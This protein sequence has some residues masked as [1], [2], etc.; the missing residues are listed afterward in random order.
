MIISDEVKIKIGSKSSK[1]YR[2]KKYVFNRSGDEIT[3]KIE[4]LLPNTNVNVVVKCDFCNNVIETN[5]KKYYRNFNSNNLSLFSCCAKCTGRKIRMLNFKKYGVEFV[6]QLESVKIKTK[7]N[8]FKNIK[9]YGINLLSDIKPNFTNSLITKE[10]IIRINKWNINHFKELG[11]QNLIL[12]YKWIVPVEHLMKYSSVKVEGKCSICGKKQMLTFQKFMNN[13]E[14]SNFYSCTH[15]NNKTLK[16][17][18]QKKYGVD[19][20]AHNNEFINKK[21]ETCLKKYGNEH[22]I[23]S[24]DIKK[25]IRTTLYEKFGGH[26]MMNEEIK[27]TI[28]SKGLKT[29]LKRG[30]IIPDDKLTDWQLYR[31]IV[32]KMTEKNRKIL[33]ENWDGFDFYDNEYI[34]NNFNL[35]FKDKNFPTIDH[36]ISIFYGFVNNVPSEEISNISNLCFTK[37]QIN[38]I[39]HTLLDIEYKK[40][41]QI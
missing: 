36:K 20:P 1:Y 30:L 3:V 31:K 5:Y 22:A 19:N 27:N 24:E 40:K 33:L 13:Y 10:V 7:E 34:K 14:R 28:I 4:D 21:K 37:R 6:N 18:M 17:T 26:Q 8:S 41:S 39:K 38:S 32:R 2:D 16:I 11:Y 23:A 15:C 35:N 9:R 29:K 12:N 25:K